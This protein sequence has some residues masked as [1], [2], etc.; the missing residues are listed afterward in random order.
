MSHTHSHGDELGGSHS[1][2]HNDPFGG[3]GH[4]HEILDGPGSYLH[5]EQPI[6]EDRD[7]K[8]R[9]YTIGIGGYS[10]HSTSQTS[11]LF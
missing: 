6:I 4:S 7:W 2:A 11:M 3:H 10:I 5:R 1:H 9:A 8:D